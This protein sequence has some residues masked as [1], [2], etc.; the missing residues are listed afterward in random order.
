MRVTAVSSYR[1]SLVSSFL[2]IT[3]AGALGSV[4]DLVKHTFICLWAIQYLMTPCYVS[5]WLAPRVLNSRY[6][7]A[8]C[9]RQKRL[10]SWL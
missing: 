1:V 4:L 10:P 9:P 7:H 6:T 3:F 2:L 8:G 5:T